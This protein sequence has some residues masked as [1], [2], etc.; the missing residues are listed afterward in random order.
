MTEAT[1]GQ[2]IITENLATIFYGKTLTHAGN[3]VAPSDFPFSW[4]PGEAFHTSIHNN[5]HNFAQD[6]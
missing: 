3:N 1:T 2:D 6:S 4:V 5:R